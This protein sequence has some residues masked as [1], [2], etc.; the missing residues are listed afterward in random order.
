[1]TPQST[2]KT[3]DFKPHQLSASN[4]SSLFNAAYI[5]AEALED[6]DVC[7][8][9][10]EI[11]QFIC[12]AEEQNMIHFLNK[13]KA[14]KDLKEEEVNKLINAINA[15]LTLIKASLRK[16]DHG[17]LIIDFEYDY[18][19]PKQDTISAK[20]L[21]QL[22]R[23]FENWVQSSGSIYNQFHPVQAQK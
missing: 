5:D 16:D 9:K 7:V 3:M 1:M 14:P 13:T 17:D 23:V 6:C 18:F 12:V 8:V 11:T 20:T 10:G 4:L 2:L 19:I 22:S 15:Q 21:I